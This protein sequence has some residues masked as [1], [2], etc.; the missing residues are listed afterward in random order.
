MVRREE[1]RRGG[2]C[3]K[4]CR[5]PLRHALSTSQHEQRQDSIA[6]ALQRRPVCSPDHA[7]HLLMNHLPGDHRP[8]L[9]CA[10][11]DAARPAVPP[12]LQP[13]RPVPFSRPS[14]LP[15]RFV[16]RWAQASRLPLRPPARRPSSTPNRARGPSRFVVTLPVF[17]RRPARHS[18]PSFSSWS[19]LYP[20]A[21]D[22]KRAW[23]A[24][25]AKPCGVGYRAGEREESP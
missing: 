23:R 4:S 6:I 24:M 2:A 13:P 25:G 11:V 5:R 12:A 22:T 19:G 9:L 3:R 10:P 20:S 8:L 18:S 1:R 14:L 17:A 7:L 21:Q 16:K 15:F